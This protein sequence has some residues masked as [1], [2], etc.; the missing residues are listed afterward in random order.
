M[1]PMKTPTLLTLEADPQAFA[2]ITARIAARRAQASQT[3]PPPEDWPP[4]RPSWRPSPAALI[5]GSILIIHAILWA[6]GLI[7]QINL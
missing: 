4:G 1:N 2:R 5:I 3:L 7:R 6:A